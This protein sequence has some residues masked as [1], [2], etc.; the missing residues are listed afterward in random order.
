MD[1]IKGEIV[2]I[3]SGNSTD[4]LASELN[5]LSLEDH[6]KYY[7]D[8]TKDPKLSYKLTARDLGISKSEVYNK[9][10]K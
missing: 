9:L 5:K 10:N 6:Y 8:T 1:E 4:F 2:L 7:L 3:V